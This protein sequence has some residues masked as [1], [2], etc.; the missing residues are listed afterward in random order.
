MSFTS[1]VFLVFLAA[2]FLLYWPLSRRGQNVLLLLASLVFYGW[3]DWR[4][5]FLLLSAAGIDYGVALALARTEAARS[6]RA[7][8]LVSLG[9]NLG[10]LATFKYF[11]FF[12]ASLAALLRGL[13]LPEAP[14]ALHLTLP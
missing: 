9:A 5:L 4:F 6:R 2:V 1:P 12:A 14:W 13:G 10:V 8:L 11:D 3:W 7:L